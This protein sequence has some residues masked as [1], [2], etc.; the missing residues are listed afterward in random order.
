VGLPAR[1]SR[2]PSFQSIAVAVA[3]AIDREHAKTE[4]GQRL[5]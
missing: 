3:R 4:R 2:L 1:R 5:G